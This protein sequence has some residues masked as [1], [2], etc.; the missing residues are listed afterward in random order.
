MTYKAFNYD[1]EDDETD[2]KDVSV[3]VAQYNVDGYEDLVIDLGSIGNQFGAFGL[4][5][6]K[7]PVNLQEKFDNWASP[8]QA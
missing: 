8:K 5:V 6:Y 3:V 4:G 7:V 1:T 2:T